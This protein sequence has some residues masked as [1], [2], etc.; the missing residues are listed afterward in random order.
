MPPKTVVPSFPNTSLETLARE[1]GEAMTGTELTRLLEEAGVANSSPESTKWKRIYGNLRDAQAKE[2]NGK[3]IVRFVKVAAAPVR[4][5]G[6]PD[7]YEEF[8]AAINVTLSLHGL[9]LRDDDVLPA[10]VDR[11]GRDVL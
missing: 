7:Q 10:G 8:R 3:P 6:S 4:F 5:V 11:L 1:L 9:E 2:G